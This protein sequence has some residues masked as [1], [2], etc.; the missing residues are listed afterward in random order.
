MIYDRLSNSLISMGF[1]SV[2]SNARGIYIFY[3]AEEQVVNIVSVF[4]AMNGDEFSLEQYSHILV[5]IKANFSN[6]YPQ[7]LSLLN[8]ILTNNPEGARHLCSAGGEDSHWMIDLNKNRLMLYETQSNNFARLKNRIEALLEEEWIDGQAQRLEN[9]GQTTAGN[10]R[11]YHAPSLGY[12]RISIQNLFTPVNMII[13][14]VNIFAFFIY[15]YSAFLGGEE[16]IFS[17]GAL[18][19]Y[20]IREDQEYYRI[21]TAM[22]MHADWSHLINNMIVLLFIGNHVEKIAGK[23]KYLILYFGTGIIAGITSISYNMWKEYPLN[24]YTHLTVSIGASGAI[25]GVVGAMLYIVIVNRGRI[26]NISMRQMILFVI[27]SLYGGIANA[28]IDQAAH[29]GGFL[30]GVLLA[31][32]IYRKPRT[33]A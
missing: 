15:H 13:I 17:R 22:F 27:L 25:F 12:R 21:L 26:Q 14:A 16:N 6:N 24:S 11:N 7:T 4:F 28:Q 30:A 32:V 20:F 5:Q 18:S 2:N 9:E 33:A 3:H 31:A 1:Q 10:Y 8:L 19:W 29:V 23:L